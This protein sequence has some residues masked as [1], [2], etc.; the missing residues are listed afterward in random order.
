MRANYW[1]LWIQKTRLALELFRDAKENDDLSNRAVYVD[2]SANASISGLVS[3]WVQL[4]I[5]GIVVVDNCDVSLHDRMKQEIQRADSK[6]GLL[7]LDY[8]LEKSSQTATVHL[9][10]FVR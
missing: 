3:D 7:T 2:A 6:M 1:A 9:K 10:Q 8:N 4:G 5:E